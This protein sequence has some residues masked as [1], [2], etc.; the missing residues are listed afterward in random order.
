[1]SFR[2]PMNPDNESTIV[3]RTFARLCAQARPRV[4]SALVPRHD[5]AHAVMAAIDSAT[6]SY[7]RRI[8]D[9][10]ISNT[11]YTLTTA[12]ARALNKENDNEQAK[13]WFEW[14]DQVTAEGER[15]PVGKVMKANDYTVS[16][17]R[18]VPVL[19]ER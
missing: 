17:G 18:R 10:T 7:R 3:K 4:P 16:R 1:M 14:F 15:S 11:G 19:S 9:V 6:I 8:S 2:G 5:A 12:P 13:S